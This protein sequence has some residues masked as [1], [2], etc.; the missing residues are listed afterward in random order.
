MK[1]KVTLNQK[2][3]WET[4]AKGIGVPLDKTNSIEFIITK[5]RPPQPEH[6][7]HTINLVTG[8]NITFDEG[9]EAPVVTK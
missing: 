6:T 9:V 3:L 1:Q 2:E 7:D 5:V 8:V 4:L